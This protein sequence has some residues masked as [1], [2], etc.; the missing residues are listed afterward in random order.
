VPGVKKVFKVR[1]LVFNIHTARALLLIATSTWA[2]LQGR[3][4]LK[5]VWDDDGFEHINT[6]DIISGASRKI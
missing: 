4:A 3:K 5:V 1:M 6:N 2:A